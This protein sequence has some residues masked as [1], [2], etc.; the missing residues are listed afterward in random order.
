[1]MTTKTILSTISPASFRTLLSAKRSRV[2]PVDATW[3]MPNNPKDGKQEFLKQ[4]RISNSAFF[5][6]DEISLPGTKY[7]HTLPTYEKFTQS[8]RELGIAKDDVLVVYDKSGIFS[9]PRAA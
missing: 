4:E 6:L 3:Y 5:D 1:M 9:S 8:V 7:P 2:I